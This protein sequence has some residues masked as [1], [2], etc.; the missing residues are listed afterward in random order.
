M[1]LDHILDMEKYGCRAI[2][3]LQAI[4]LKPD[5]YNSLNRLEDLVANVRHF[6]VCW[7]DQRRLED[8]GEMP[9]GAAEQIRQQLTD[10]LLRYLI[11]T[12]F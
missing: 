3:A 11:P 12:R 4:G 7:D 5:A 1:T 6:A 10:E 8:A 9:S 2:N